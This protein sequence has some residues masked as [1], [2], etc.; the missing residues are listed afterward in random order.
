MEERKEHS[1]RITDIDVLRGFALFGILP[2]NIVQMTGQ[3]SPGAAF[4]TLLQG[5]FFPIFSFLFG[6]SA[7][8]FLRGAGR[9]DLLWRFMTL[10]PFG[11]LH[12]LGQPGEVLLPYAVLGA[13]FLLPAS[14]VSASAVLAAGLLMT[15]GAM[16]FTSGGWSLVPGLFLLGAA[17]MRREAFSL[18]T[19]TLAKAFA[20]LAVA[21]A[22]LNVWQLGPADE[23]VFGTAGVVTAAAYGTGL[24][25][26]LRTG[27]RPAL[28]AVLEPM[29]RLALTCYVSATPLILL[30]DR[31]YGVDDGRDAAALTLVILSAQVMFARWW[32]RWFRYGPLEWSW[33][34]LTR[35]RLEPL[36]VAPVPF[37]PIRWGRCR[38][39]R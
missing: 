33:R 34:S 23:R 30:A 21:A 28:T 24:L 10:V 13:A 14:Y 1:G 29:G 3:P 5:R 17:A 19:R 22:A 4:D 11:V 26:L 39:I 27:A 16:G 35:R 38:G 2:V 12:Q 31:L 7:V 6:T 37:P 9:A 8:L 18:P 25:L 15:A 36:R 32:S 20:V